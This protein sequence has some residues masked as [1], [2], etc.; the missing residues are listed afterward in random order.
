M[1][2]GEKS[3]LLTFGTRPELI[4]LAP[5]I[6]LLKESELLS[7]LLIVNTNQHNEL[8]TD[9]LN[10]WNIVVDINLNINRSKNNLTFLLSHTLLEYQTVFENYKNLEYIIV[11]GDTNTALAITKN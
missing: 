10:V 3:I 6:K 11:Q 1:N 2:N 4:K 8:L 7:K 5:V 9:Q